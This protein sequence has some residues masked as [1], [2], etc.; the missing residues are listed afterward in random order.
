MRGGAGRDTF[1]W[2]N[3]FETGA[4]P[5]FADQVADL[6]RADRLDLSSI[7]A[8]TNRLGDQAFSFVGRA[9]FSNTAGELRFGNGFLI[10]DQNGDGAGDFYITVGGA[11]QI[12][13]D[14]LVL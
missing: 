3:E 8:D 14:A 11:F 10:A 12:L 13:E 7:D 9:G 2:T 5:Q 4:R 1:A 6:T